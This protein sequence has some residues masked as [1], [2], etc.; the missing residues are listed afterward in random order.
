MKV[1]GESGRP[2]WQGKFV[3]LLGALLT[4]AADDQELEAASRELK[5][6]V[7]HDIAAGWPLPESTL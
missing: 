6:F 2:P 5:E 7:K 4:A 1:A 3:D